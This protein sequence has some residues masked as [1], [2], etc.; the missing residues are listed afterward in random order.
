MA[1]DI[2]STTGFFSIKKLFSRN[3][4]LS[5][6]LRCLLK[7]IHSTLFKFSTGFFSCCIF[8][9]LEFTPWK[10]EQPLEGT[11]LKE[12]ETQKD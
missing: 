2:V 8:F 9:Y 3:E 6:F 7:N 1:T 10:A 12:K 5:K 4:N 11:K